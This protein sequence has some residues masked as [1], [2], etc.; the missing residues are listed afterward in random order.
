MRVSQRVLTELGVMLTGCSNQQ[1][2]QGEIS[3][4]E[5]EQIAHYPVQAPFAGTIIGKDVVIDERVVPERRMFQLADLS[6]LWVEADIYQEDLERLAHVGQT[7]LFRSPAYD[8]DHQ[9]QVFY[10]ERYR[11]KT[12]RYPWGCRKSPRPMATSKR[13]PFSSE[14]AHVCPTRHALTSP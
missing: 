9:A 7:V 1:Y 12:P 3:R 2:A 14:E 8:H 10:Y 6:S 4:E 13:R 11:R 5:Y